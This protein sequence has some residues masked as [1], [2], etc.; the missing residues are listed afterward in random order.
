MLATGIMVI[1]NA[2]LIYPPEYRIEVIRLFQITMIPALGVFG[3]IAL[4]QAKLMGDSDAYALAVVIMLFPGL[5]IYQIPFTGVALPHTPNHFRVHAVSIIANA[6]LVGGTI[7]LVLMVKNIAAGRFNDDLLLNW[8]PTPQLESEYGKLAIRETGESIDLD[9]IRMYLRWR[10]ATHGELINGELD[11]SNIPETRRVSDGRVRT[12]IPLII[13]QVDRFIAPNRGLKG[14][15]RKE[16][17]N[18]PGDQWGAEFFF[19]DVDEDL[20][21][22]RLRAALD[23]LAG[24]KNSM[25]PIYPGMPFI[26]LLFIGLVLSLTVGDM[27]AVGLTSSPP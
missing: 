19:E 24:E 23:Q 7:P 27:V 26:T 1:A 18:T 25:Q 11:D 13:R 9:I 16:Q 8:I 10:S 5:I 2:V 20:P 22:D 4:V 17:Q 21:P 15:R 14:N 6:F 3:A 12:G